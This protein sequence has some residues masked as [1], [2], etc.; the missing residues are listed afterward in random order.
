MTLSTADQRARIK[1]LQERDARQTLPELQ[2]SA[3]AL[4]EMLV[5]DNYDVPLNSSC[6][7]FARCTRPAAGTVTHPIMGEV[8]CCKECA[9]A[10]DLDL[11]VPDGTITESR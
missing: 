3:R 6:E 7:W 1:K 8:P 2:A 4:Y 5:D 9:E 11:E 10:L